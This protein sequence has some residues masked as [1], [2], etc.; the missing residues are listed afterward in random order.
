MGGGKFSTNSSSRYLL[1]KLGNKL[2]K[3]LFFDLNI[4]MTVAD[5]RAK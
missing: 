3:K 4:V 2:K 1:E 5:A